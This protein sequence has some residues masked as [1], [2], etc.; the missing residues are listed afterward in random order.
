MER[1]SNRYDPNA[2]MQRGT[3]KNDRRQERR[4]ESE[5]ESILVEETG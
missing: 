5:K 2:D 3:L 1:L 4:H